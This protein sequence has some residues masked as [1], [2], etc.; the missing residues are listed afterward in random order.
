MLCVIASVSV[1][2]RPGQVPASLVNHTVYTRTRAGKRLSFLNISDMLV[3]GVTHN[4]TN[5][6]GR[7]LVQWL[8]LKCKSNLNVNMETNL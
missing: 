3:R 5:A 8:V 1:V 2:S 4:K 7:L 6:I